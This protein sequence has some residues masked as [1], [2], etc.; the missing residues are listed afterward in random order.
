MCDYF[1]TCFLLLSSDDD[2]LLLYVITHPKLNQLYT[3][4]DCF[5]QKTKAEMRDSNF[6]RTFFLFIPS[7]EKCCSRLDF[8]SYG[9]KITLNFV[10]KFS[11]VFFA[12]MFFT[13]ALEHT[14]YQK[15]TFCLKLI[16]KITIL[17]YLLVQI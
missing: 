16:E 9:S 7:V 14:L 3:L 12:L 15:F 2:S 1:R 13:I 11:A 17:V 4:I 6:S 8:K 5:I 10:L